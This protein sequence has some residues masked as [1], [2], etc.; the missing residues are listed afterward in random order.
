[1]AT[2]LG[3]G[4]GEHP[5]CSA[6]IYQT[7]NPPYE[8]WLEEA[9]GHPDARRYDPKPRDPPPHGEPAGDSLYF[10]G[11]SPQGHVSVNPALAGFLQSCAHS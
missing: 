5:A 7:L 8:R 4:G 9:R 10:R 6:G 1:M 3:F 2:E 11:I